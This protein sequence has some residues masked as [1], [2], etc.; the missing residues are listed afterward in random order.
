MMT[1][2][3]IDDDCGEGLGKEDKEKR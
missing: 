2:L 1:V 3:V